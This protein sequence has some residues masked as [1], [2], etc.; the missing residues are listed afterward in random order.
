M[1]RICIFFP[2]LRGG[3]GEVS[4]E[5]GFVYLAPEKEASV[6]LDGGSFILFG[7]EFGGEVERVLHSRV[8]C[9]KGRFLLLEWR[10]PSVG[11]YEEEGGV[12]EVWVR[13]L[14]LPLHP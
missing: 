2:F 14:G 6:S 10:N 5:L 13:I 8:S 9:F 1:G 12:C 11:F 7:F 4:D 3:W